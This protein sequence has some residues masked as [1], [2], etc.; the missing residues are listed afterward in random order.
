MSPS[1]TPSNA[2]TTRDQSLEPALSCKHFKRLFRGFRNF[3]ITIDLYISLL[4]QLKKF[5]S[6][7]R[8]VSLLSGLQWKRSFMAHIQRKA[9]C[10]YTYCDSTLCINVFR[11][12]AYSKTA[13][14][15]FTCL[16]ITTYLARLR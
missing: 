6:F 15:I 1:S 5:C 8:G 10:E 7:F 12:M 2:N 14:Y 11:T 16:I 3:I 9:M 4:Y 13:I